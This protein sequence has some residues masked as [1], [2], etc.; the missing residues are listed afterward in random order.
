[1][2]SLILD[3]LFAGVKKTAWLVRIWAKS[4]PNGDVYLIPSLT[5]QEE[6]LRTLNSSNETAPKFIRSNINSLLMDYL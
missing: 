5:S 2:Y 6:A 3:A 1:M 4:S